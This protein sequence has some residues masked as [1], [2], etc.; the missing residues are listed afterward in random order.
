MPPILEARYSLAEVAALAGMSAGALYKSIA[1]QTLT[2][3]RKNGGQFTFSFSDVVAISAFADLMRA[4]VSAQ[5]ADAAA[6]QITDAELP[7]HLYVRRPKIEAWSV[8]AHGPKACVTLAY[9]YDGLKA[10]L[11][12]AGPNTSTLTRLHTLTLDIAEAIDALREGAR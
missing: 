11:S 2:V 5:D 10:A 3:A 4:G 7:A 6:C 12:A 8:V 1:R 9:G